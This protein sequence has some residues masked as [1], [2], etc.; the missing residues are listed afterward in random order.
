MIRYLVAGLSS[1][2]F[3]CGCAS[4]GGPPHPSGTLYGWSGPVSW[5]VDD[6][7]IGPLK[8]GNG[9]RWDYTV[10]LREFT[11]TTIQFERVERTWRS[12]GGGPPNVTQEPFT[13][14]LEARAELR[15][16]RWDGIGWGGGLIPLIGSPPGARMWVQLR[17]FGRDAAGNDVMVNVSLYFDE[18][19]AY[20]VVKLPAEGT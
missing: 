9:I 1:L 6:L 2:A 11:G 3:A 8:D 16:R 10:I 15:H 17:F 5:T 4:Q 20:A 14:R 19:G 13:E 18:Y 7:T 12:E